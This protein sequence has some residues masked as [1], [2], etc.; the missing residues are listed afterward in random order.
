MADKL[1]PWVTGLDPSQYVVTAAAI[2]V[3]VGRVA[4]I[5]H[6]GQTLPRGYTDIAQLRH[7]ITLG[8]IAKRAQS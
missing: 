2:Q 4:S 5:L 3:T 6:K 1:N 7:L 8:M